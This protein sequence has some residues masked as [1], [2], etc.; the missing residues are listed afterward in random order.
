MNISINRKSNFSQKDAIMSTTNLIDQKSEDT[1]DFMNQKV[2]W[3]SWQ[4]AHQRA[5]ECGCH[6]CLGWLQNRG[7]QGDFLCGEVAGAPD[8][9]RPVKRVSFEQWLAGGNKINATPRRKRKRN[10]KAETKSEEV[11]A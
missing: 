1:F 7:Y 11:V 2:M 9:N 3:W 5:R 10:V 8:R 6:L 4:E